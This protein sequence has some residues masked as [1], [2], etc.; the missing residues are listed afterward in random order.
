M[1]IIKGITASVV[2]DHKYAREYPCPGSVTR[3]PRPDNQDTVYI[4]AKS[5]ASFYFQ[6]I[7]DSDFDWD[8]TDLVSA[9]VELN[10]REAASNS[11][12]KDEPDSDGTWCMTLD[13]VC[14]QINEEDYKQHKW[15]FEQMDTSEYKTVHFHML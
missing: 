11:V 8:D 12:N 5:E 4:Q 6:V 7:I 1:G 10:G 2:I 9:V 15:I 3:L 14:K 13:G